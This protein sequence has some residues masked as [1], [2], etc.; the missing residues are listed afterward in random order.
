MLYYRGETAAAEA[1]VREVLAS[2]PEMDSVRPLLAMCLSRHGEHEAARAELTER[3][4]AGAAADPD[5]AYWLAS[6]FALEGERDEAF[7][8]L[9]RAIQ[10]RPRGS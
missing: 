8:W 4:K 3:V 5:I 9:Q 6:A 2:H 7:S 10:S 1:L